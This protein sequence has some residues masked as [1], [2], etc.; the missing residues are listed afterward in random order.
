MML[1]CCSNG[2]VRSL[3][4]RRDLGREARTRRG[5]S[6][7]CHLISSGMY[8]LSSDSEVSAVRD[9]AA[10]P[11]APAHHCSAYQHPLYEIVQLDSEVTSRSTVSIYRD[12]GVFVSTDR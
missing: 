8:P 10:A 11:T 3:V 9:G 6:R 2:D 4:A 7:A 1:W 12:S 5:T